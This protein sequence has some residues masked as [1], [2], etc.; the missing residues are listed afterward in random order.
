MYW[1]F[2]VTGERERERASCTGTVG[3][4]KGAN[5]VV[6]PT[7][8]TGSFLV[9]L[10]REPP[11]SSV[12]LSRPPS[13]SK[14]PTPPARSCRPAPTRSRSGGGGDRRSRAPRHPWWPPSSGQWLPTRWAAKGRGGTR[15]K[16]PRPLGWSPPLRGEEVPAG[17]VPAEWR[18]R[19]RTL[20]GAL[21]RQAASTARTSPRH[22]NALSPAHKSD[23]LSA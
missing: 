11:H 21:T 15:G 1:R 10:S 20:V 8:V 6:N 5:A 17:R 9:R 19:R 4:E 12:L 16:R 14:S 18:V 23:R 2:G 22:G 3:C 13:R 7:P